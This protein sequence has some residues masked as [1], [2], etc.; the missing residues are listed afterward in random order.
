L[1]AV[2]R[3]HAFTSAAANY[4]PRARALFASVRRRHPEWRLHLVLAEPEAPPGLAAFVGADEV[5][6]IDDLGIPAWRAWAFGH[7]LV[8]LATALKP[9]LLRRLL[10]RADCDAAVYLDP[11]VVVFSALTEVVEGLAS[12]SILLTPH[13]TTPATDTF[14]VIADEICTLQHG[15]YNL[16]FIAVADRPEGRRFARWWAERTYRFCRVDLPSGLF[17]DQ[18]WADLAPAFFEEVGILRSPRL[19]VA[20]WNLAGRPLTGHPPDGLRVAGKPLGFFHFSGIDRNPD[21]EG[22]AAR[23]LVAW[24]RARTSPPNGEPG[25]PWGFSRFADGAPVE[26]AQRLVFRLRGDLQQAFPDPFA[27]GEGTFQAW[28][29]TQAP[30]EFPALFDPAGRE[31][32]LARLGSALTTGYADLDLSE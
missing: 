6:A 4:L 27:S 13:Q 5:H 24:Y 14:G 11:D 2:R 31:A 23:G 1:S 10:A 15:T 18:R 21:P 20:P 22:E 3:I 28:W 19:N 26:R 17:T 30:I 7:E 29:P 9:F 12:S 25:W 32:E 16:G 8:E